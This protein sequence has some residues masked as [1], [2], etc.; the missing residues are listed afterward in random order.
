M[1]LKILQIKSPLPYNNKMAFQIKANNNDGRV[2]QEHHTNLPF[3]R[4]VNQFTDVIQ[5]DEILC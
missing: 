4:F 5:I 1:K 2:M 3:L